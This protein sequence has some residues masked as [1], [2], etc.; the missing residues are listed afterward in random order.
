MSL[1]PPSTASGRRRHRSQDESLHM[2]LG[3]SMN[4]DMQRSLGSKQQGVHVKAF[5]E[6]D[7]V[8]PPP[9]QF[10]SKL[11][12]A[13]ASVP[14]ED[15]RSYVHSKRVTHYQIGSTLG[16][17]SFA[18]VKEGFHVL[19]GEKVSSDL[20]MNGQYSAHTSLCV[21]GCSKGD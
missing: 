21:V 5:S 6:S 18:K 12:A 13:V 8:L 20:M 19:V 11:P 14:L 15:V 10:V 9:P 4:G 16:E 3:R 17:G 7:K 2:T 1:L